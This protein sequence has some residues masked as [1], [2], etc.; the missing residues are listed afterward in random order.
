[1]AGIAILLLAGG[2]SSRMGCDKAELQWQG[3]PLL[4]WQAERFASLAEVVISGP[5]GIPDDWHDYRGPLAG[6]LAASKA[7]PDISTWIVIPVD[8]PWLTL[9]TVHRLMDASEE[10]ATAQAFTGYP[11]PMSLP[12]NADTLK[13]LKAAL[14]DPEG[15]RALRWLHRQLNGQWLQPAPPVSEMMNANTP[16]EWAEAKRL[17]RL[18][19]GDTHEQA[20]Q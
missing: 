6:V 9:A 8:M 3:Q 19:S 1:M 11:L 18:S 10:R 17:N 12:V 4:H 20:Q 13:I 15:P 16:E 2:R 7:R 5:K 14:A